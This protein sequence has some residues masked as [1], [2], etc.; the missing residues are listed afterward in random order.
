MLTGTTEHACSGELML[1]RKLYFLIL[2][3]QSQLPINC[4]PFRQPVKISARKYYNL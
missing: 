2:V 4:T 3:I 1:V